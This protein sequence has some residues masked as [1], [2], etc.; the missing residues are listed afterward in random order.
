MAGFK[1]AVEAARARSL[2]PD[3]K[4]CS[5]HVN[6]SIAGKDVPKVE[7]ILNPLGYYLSAWTD[8]TTVATF[9]DGEQL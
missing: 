7:P 2:T 5:V 4:G 3:Y 6:A 1:E 8:G 9:I